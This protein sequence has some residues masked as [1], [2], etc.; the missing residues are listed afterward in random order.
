MGL[1]AVVI[2]PDTGHIPTY[3]VPLMLG[4]PGVALGLL[5]GGAFS[6]FVVVGHGKYQTH[7]GERML[8]GA[9]IGAVAGQ[10]IVWAFS[11]DGFVLVVPV[12]IGAWFSAAFGNWRNSKSHEEITS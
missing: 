12:I 6:C 5:A 1:V 11:L 2:H 10:I 4:I 3:A 7:L 8:V 9:V